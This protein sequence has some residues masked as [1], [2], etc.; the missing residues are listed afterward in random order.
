MQSRDPVVENPPKPHGQNGEPLFDNRVRIVNEKTGAIVRYQPYAHHIFGDNK[1]E[2]LERPIGSGNM[3]NRMGM[4]IGQWKMGDNGAWKKI[5]DSHL[6]IRLDVPITKEDA[7]LAKNEALEADLKAI[8][9]EKE[10]LEKKL[11]VSK[12]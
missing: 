3:F 12:K 9:A 7:L 11:T 5:S 1:M 6:D 2:L 10:A 8:R 4:N